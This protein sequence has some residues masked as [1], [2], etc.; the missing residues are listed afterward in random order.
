MKKKCA[1]ILA[2]GF[3]TRY[4]EDKRL[5]GSK[6]LLDQILQKVCACFE[7]VYVVH[8]AYDPDLL[9]YIKAYDVIGIAAPIADISLGTSISVGIEYI[10]KKNNISVCAIFLADMPYISMQSII[11]LNIASHEKTI[12]RPIYQDI[13][14]HPVLFGKVF[15]PELLDLKGKNGAYPVIKNNLHHLILLD[16]DDAGCICDVDQPEDKE[17]YEKQFLNC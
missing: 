10:Q 7:T 14:G 1:L 4:G 2:A 15:F 9:T 16:L 17:K 6:P 13:S 5:S 11:K 3:S 12:V 8:R